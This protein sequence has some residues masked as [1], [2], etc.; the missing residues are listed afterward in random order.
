MACPDETPGGCSHSLQEGGLLS[1]QDN[2]STP[3][4]DTHQGEGPA[5]EK[6]QA[7]SF[8]PDN[9]ADSQGQGAFLPST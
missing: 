9:L 8:F 1:S 5:W 3:L 6:N 2:E 4:E 7:G